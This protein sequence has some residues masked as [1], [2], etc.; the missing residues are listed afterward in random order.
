MFV[1]NSPQSGI[2]NPQSLFIMLFSAQ[3][4]QSVIKRLLKFAIKF[5]YCFSFFGGMLKL[6]KENAL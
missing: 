2:Q 1:K 5:Q 6:K 3:N 4:L